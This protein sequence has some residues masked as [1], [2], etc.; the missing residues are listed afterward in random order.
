[1]WCRSHFFL[2][3][4]A[5]GSHSDWSVFLNTMRLLKYVL[6]YEQ[7]FAYIDPD[8][9][10]TG[11]T[12]TWWRFTVFS[13]FATI[14]VD[15]YDEMMNSKEACLLQS[16]NKYS[17]IL[18][19]WNDDACYYINRAMTGWHNQVTG[20]TK[21]AGMNTANNVPFICYQHLHKKHLNVRALWY[22]YF[23]FFFFQIL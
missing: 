19:S 6:N 13:N 23:A 22:M 9:L 4:Q 20:S 7:H 17:L 8:Y 16:L 1:M 10:P 14:Y 12:A 15:F 2:H 3:S 18:W 21:F 5:L 11:L